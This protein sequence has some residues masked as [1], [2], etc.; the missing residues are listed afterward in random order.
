MTI[1]LPCRERCFEE[2]TK[3][4]RT[5]GRREKT[6]VLVMFLEILDQ[7][8]PEAKSSFRLFSYMSQYVSLLLLFKQFKFNFLSVKKGF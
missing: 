3:K 2:A 5:S 8:M 6:R 4:S 7:T 1:W